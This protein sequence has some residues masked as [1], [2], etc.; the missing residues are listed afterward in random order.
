M[1]YLCRELVPQRYI[2]VFNHR[3]L[4]LLLCGVPEIDVA[5]MRRNTTYIDSTLFHS[6]HYPWK[7][8]DI[9]IS[10]NVSFLEFRVHSFSNLPPKQLH[11]LIFFLSSFP[12]Y[13]HHLM[14]MMYLIIHDDS[15]F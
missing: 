14:I 13:R 7:P 1:L 15:I 12:P 9:C 5:D 6:M 11:F 3:E 10:T 2:S 8:S 4:E